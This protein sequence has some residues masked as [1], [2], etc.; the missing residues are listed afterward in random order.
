[1]TGQACSYMRD[2]CVYVAQH[3]ICDCAAKKKPEKER[4]NP[5]GVQVTSQMTPL[6]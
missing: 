5:A 2:F 3:M 4:K 1:M 6:G